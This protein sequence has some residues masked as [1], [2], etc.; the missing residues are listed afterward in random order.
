MLAICRFSCL[1]AT[2]RCEVLNA[3]LAHLSPSHLGG[4]MP[5][6]R[7]GAPAMI[8]KGFILTKEFRAMRAKSLRHKKSF[9]DHE[10]ACNYPLTLASR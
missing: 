4:G 8:A 9:R 3:D 5:E 2:V 6:R 1:G 10:P 7:L